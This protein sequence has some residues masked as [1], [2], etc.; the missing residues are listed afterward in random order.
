M[1]LLS[2]MAWS[3]IGVFLL[4]AAITFIIA[5]VLFIGPILALVKKDEEERNGQE[6]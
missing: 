2:H 6:W 5:D 1:K 3:I 4:V